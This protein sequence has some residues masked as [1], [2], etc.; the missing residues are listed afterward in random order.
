MPFG[1]LS[2]FELADTAAAHI[3]RHVAQIDRTVARTS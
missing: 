2:L 3:T 1:T